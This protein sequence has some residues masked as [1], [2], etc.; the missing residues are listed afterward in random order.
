MH[1]PCIEVPGHDAIFIGDPK[2]ADLRALL[3]RAGFQTELFGGVIVC[4]RVVQIRKEV[5]PYTKDRQEMY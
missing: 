1:L 2:L 3:T 5:L 4:N